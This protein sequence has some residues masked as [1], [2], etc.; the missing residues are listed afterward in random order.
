MAQ[1]CHGLC[2]AGSSS[3]L[4]VVCCSCVVAD[5]AVCANIEQGSDCC[6]CLHVAPVRTVLIVLQNFTLPVW[7]HPLEHAIDHTRD[8]SG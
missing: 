5:D 8:S 7:F 1:V 3:T 2:I 6:L 4:Q